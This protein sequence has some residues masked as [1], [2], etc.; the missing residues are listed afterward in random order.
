MDG[1][2]P[3]R[4]VWAM[5]N[6]QSESDAVIIGV[7]DEGSSHSDRNGVSQAPKRIREI[8]NQRE[9]FSRMGNTSI[10][11][12][13]AA[14]LKKRIFD[15]GD[16]AKKDVAR[17]VEELIID[18]RMPITIGGDHSI[19]AEVLKGVDNAIGDVSVVYFD[20][21]PDFICSSS[22][23]YGSVVCD[24]D[25][26]SAI[27]FSHSVEVGIRC[28]EP[29]E[30]INI[31]HSKLRTITPNELVS[32]GMNTAVEIIRKTVGE[33]IYISLDVDVVDPAFAPG[34]SSPV[35][36][37]LTSAEIFFMLSKLSSMNIVGFDV[38]E[39]CPPYDVQDM[40]SHLAARLV[41]LGAP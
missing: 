19:T 25:R 20:A 7:P 24:V 22:E 18:G 4:F 32:I 21:H 3:P 37:G 6:E 34:V 17:T 40:T 10:A 2:K 31:R 9:M 36:G 5:A 30:L 33:N 14:D 16:I 26:Y 39:V 13:R 35:P 8:S 1:S 38:M 12:P 41:V 29:E 27:D 11:V 15:H 28:A 23:Y